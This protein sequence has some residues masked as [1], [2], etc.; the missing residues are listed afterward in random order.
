VPGQGAPAEPAVNV[1]PPQRSSP[2]K[3]PPARPELSAEAR[4][5]IADLQRAL[6]AHGYHPGPR[7]GRLDPNTEAAIMAY[8]RDAHLPR[9]A[10]S[11]E[12]LRL[13]IHSVYY[14]EP[15]IMAH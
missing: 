11:V 8:Q 10:R 15:P 14:A 6:P 7:T 2:P 3:R 9:D 12:A 13:T 1:P 5:Y 4:T